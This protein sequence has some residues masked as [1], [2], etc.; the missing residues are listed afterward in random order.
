MPEI[1]VR[2]SNETPCVLRIEKVGNNNFHFEAI[3]TNENKI[4][5]RTILDEGELDQLIQIL[6]TERES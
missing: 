1:I 4:A 5:M 6:Q 2:N 3:H